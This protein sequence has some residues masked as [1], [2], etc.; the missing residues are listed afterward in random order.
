MTTNDATAHYL[1][2]S[3][4]MQMVKEASQT[5]VFAPAD[6]AARMGKWVR[7]AQETFIVLTINARNR[8]IDMHL[9]SMGTIDSCLVHPR[10]VFRPAITDGASSIIV[11]HNHPSGVL[12]PSS[13]DIRTTRQLVRSGR[14]IDIPVM[15]HVI[16]GPVI[17]AASGAD[18]QATGWNSL[19]EAGIVNF[20]I[21]A[22][23]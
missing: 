4:R 11:S 6:V 22:I 19:R 17:G 16:V 8:L 7:A 2:F 13:E 23:A 10:E 18:T 14:I 5:G 12:V 3:S 9:V 15:D 20:S 1:S 21:K